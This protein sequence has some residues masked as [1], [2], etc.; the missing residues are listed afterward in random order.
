MYHHYFVFCISYNSM[1]LGLCVCA[2]VYACSHG[3]L[4][5][6]SVSES[7]HVCDVRYA[8]MDNVSN[9]TYLLSFVL[10]NCVSFDVC[11]RTCVCLT[12]RV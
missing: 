6:M 7:E 10:W 8:W 12:L 2:R 5:C 3:V 1:C 4:Q 9:L 11:A